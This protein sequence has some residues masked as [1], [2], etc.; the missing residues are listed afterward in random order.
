MNTD[1]D[2]CPGPDEAERLGKL[3]QLLDEAEADYEVLSHQETVASADEGVERGIGNLAQMAPTLILETERG[4][5]AAIISGETRLSYKKIK[6]VLGLRNVS[7]AGPDVVL[8]TT[9]A[10]VG[11]VSLVNQGM[12]TMVD[13]RLTKE[14][15]VYGGCGV[16]CHTLRINPLDLIRVT[17]AEVFDF[18]ET[19]QGEK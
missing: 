5:V 6:R 2:Y 10:H 19:R 15:M 16:P 11:T 17:G 12:P 3:R 13:T 14:P 18:T 8:Q 7:L 9:G 1:L 4:L